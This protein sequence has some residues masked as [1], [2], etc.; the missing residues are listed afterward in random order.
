MVE[1]SKPT[2][3]FECRVADE[4]DK[5]G[6][7]DV[8][9]EVAADIPAR[10]QTPEDQKN[11]KGFISE[12]VDVGSSLVAVDSNGLIVGF[13]LSKPDNGVRLQEKNKAFN[14]PY[15]GVSKKWQRHGVLKSLL[16]RLKDHSEPLTV[17]VLSDNKCD[18]VATLEKA[19]FVKQSRQDPKQTYLRWNPSND[20][21]ASLREKWRELGLPGMAEFDPDAYWKDARPAA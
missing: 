5:S 18:M 11:L 6:I 16:K 2:R 14:L 8:L 12:W 21:R 3:D 15:I 9:F 10:V 7:W 1:I 20:L 17:S 4:N 19:D 13:A